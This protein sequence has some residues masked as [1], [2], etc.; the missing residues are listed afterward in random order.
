M[1][2]SYGS[3]P[4][5]KS[6]SSQAFDDIEH[7]HVIEWVVVETMEEDLRRKPFL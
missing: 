7:L 2:P 5:S 3:P 4:W 1:C 6:P